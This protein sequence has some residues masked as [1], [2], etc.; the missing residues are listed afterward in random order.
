MYAAAHEIGEALRKDFDDLT[1]WGELTHLVVR[2]M[3]AA[4]LGG[5]IGYQRERVGKAAGLRTHMLVATG[6]AFFAL[7]PQLAGMAFADLSRVLQG[8][9]TGIGFIGAGAILKLEESRRVEGLTTAAGIWFTAAIGI[10]AGIG[11]LGSAILATA[12]GFIILGVLHRFESY[13]PTDG[14]ETQDRNRRP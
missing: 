10:A 2:L 8:I 13:I 5:I 7:A 1:N 11:R 12:L 4:L 3:V 6:T 14:G 9:I